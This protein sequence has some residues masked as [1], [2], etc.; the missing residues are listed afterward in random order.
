M[1][2]DLTLSLDPMSY[3]PEGPIGWALQILP[4]AFGIWSERTT[5]HLAR[6]AYL[7]SLILR[8][9]G[10]I[11]LNW[12]TLGTLTG[13]YGMPSMGVI[14]DPTRYAGFWPLTIAG[15]VLTALSPIVMIRPLVRRLRDAGV[16]KKW[17]YL[18][19]LP[20]LDF[21]MYVGLLFYP[22]SKA[23]TEPAAPAVAQT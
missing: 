13:I 16:E 23:T 22:P 14:F 18:A 15:Y 5:Q 1:D 17:A 8:L 12:I 3:M 9:I 4:A 19:V 6:G 11:I 10:L 20:Y 2:L 7:F 21:L